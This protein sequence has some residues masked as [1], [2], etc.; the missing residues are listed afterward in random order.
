MLAVSCVSQ[1]AESPLDGLRVGEVPDPEPRDGWVR[2]DLRAVA[3]N[4]HDLWSLKGVGLAA[5]RLPMILGCDGA[6]TLEDGTEVV[7]HSVI[8]D[9]DAAGG[10]ETLDP[11]RTILSELHPGTLAEQVLVPARNVVPKPASLSWKRPPACPWRS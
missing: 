5:D 7:I 11:K 4:H 8:G 10:D 6:G 1:S 9:P 2:V 3:L